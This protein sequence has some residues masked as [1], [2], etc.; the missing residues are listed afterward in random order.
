M[1]PTVLCGIVCKR[2]ISVFASGFQRR[3]KCSGLDC[4]RNEPDPQTMPDGQVRLREEGCADQHSWH[5]R[6]LLR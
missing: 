6:W 3:P 5:E 1:Q 2:C 4:V